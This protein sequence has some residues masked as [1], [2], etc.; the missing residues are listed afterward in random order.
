MKVSIFSA[1]KFEKPFLERANA[2]Y[3]YELKYFDA[4]LD[5]SVAKLA[6]GS[7]IVSAF[8]S[9]QLC[10][11]TLKVLADGGTKMIALRSAGFNHVDLTAAAELGITVTRVPAYSPHAIAEHAIALI[12]TLNR[13]THKAYNRSREGNFSLEGLMG[14]DLAGKTVGIIG[15]GKIGT[16]ACKILLGFA[17]RVVAYDKFP[18]QECKDMGVEYIDFDSLLKVSDIIS[19][20]CPLNAE[21][22]YLIDDAALGKVKDGL[23][24]INT[25]RG[26]LIDTKAAIRA[27]KTGKLGYLGIDVYEEEEDLF[28]EDQSE[29][30]I[31][32]DVFSR[33][34]SFPTVLITGHQGF[35]TSNAVECIANTTLENIQAFASGQPLANQ[36][37]A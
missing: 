29:H 34:L 27:L 7:E 4:H 23:M 25:G 22:H 14:F 16:V 33:L 20:H 12:L 8:V 30:I 2:S 19:L 6:A 1:H 32:D 5:P 11:D 35:F 17:C 37:K 10:K 24:L 13:K 36:I 31:D 21:S 28:F 15:T 18:N 9:D 3:G 26:A